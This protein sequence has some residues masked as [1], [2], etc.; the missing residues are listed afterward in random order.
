MLVQNTTLPFNQYAWITTHNSYAIEGVDPGLSSFNL[1]PRNQEDSVASQLN[2]R[3]THYP[4]YALCWLKRCS[5]WF[6][7]CMELEIDYTPIVL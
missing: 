6:L 7:G 1:A 3:M 2:V 5:L 4:I